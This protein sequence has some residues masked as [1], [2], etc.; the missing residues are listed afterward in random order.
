[1]TS[2]HDALLFLATIFWAIMIVITINLAYTMT[3]GDLRII[4]VAVHA[5]IIG[6]SFTGGTFFLAKAIMVPW[7]KVADKSEQ[8]TSH[9]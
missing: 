5:F 1:M 7:E 4:I 2:K 6:F 3:S 8:D 9:T